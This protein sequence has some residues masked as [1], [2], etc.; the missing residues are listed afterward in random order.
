MA[1]AGLDRA[2]EIASKIISGQFGGLEDDDSDDVEYDDVAA[3]YMG[4][5]SSFSRM[6]GAQK[7]KV[8]LIGGITAGVLIVAAAVGGYMY[9][10]KK[11]ALKN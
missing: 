8:Y 3:K 4:W 2:R 6:T 1:K 9:M 11:R 7:K 5:P 10:K